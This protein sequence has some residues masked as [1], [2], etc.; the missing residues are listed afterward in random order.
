MTQ[1]AWRGSI[2]TG[3]GDRHLAAMTIATPQSQ[4][5]DKDLCLPLSFPRVCHHWLGRQGYLWL[6]D[7]KA[8]AL[9]QIGE[10]LERP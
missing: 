3:W 4:F 10:D 5:G 1:T 7:L 8:M 2:S 6:G 9:M